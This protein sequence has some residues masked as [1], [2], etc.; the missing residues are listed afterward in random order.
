MPW[1]NQAISLVIIDAATGFTGLF[2]YSPIPAFGNL[3]ASVAAIAGTDPYGNTYQPGVTSYVPGTTELVQLNDGFIQWEDVSGQLW[4]I[5]PG[6]GGVPLQFIPPVTQSAIY[7]F[8]GNNGFRNSTAGTSTPEIWHAPTLGTGWATGSSAA[9]FQPVRYRLTCE[10]LVEII[11]LI[12]STSATPASTIWTMPT[13]YFNAT[14]AQRLG[15]TVNNNAGSALAGFL[16]ISTAGV[17]SLTLPAISAV[18]EDVMISVRYPL[19]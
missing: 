1:T 18:N 17:V 14:S 4:K 3:I 9:G 12:H 2:V 15:V 8:D 13:G 19:S 6:S 5:E 10:N 7:F 11:G 16:S